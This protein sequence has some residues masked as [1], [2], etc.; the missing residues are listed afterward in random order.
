LSSLSKPLVRR[1][2][3]REYIAGF[4]KLDK[5][6]DGYIDRYELEL[7]CECKKYKH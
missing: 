5:N 4:D 1:I 7:L 2:S 6:H 3:L